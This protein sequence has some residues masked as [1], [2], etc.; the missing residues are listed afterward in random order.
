[1]IDFQKRTRA[2]ARDSTVSSLADG[3]IQPLLLGG[4]SPELHITSERIDGGFLLI[5][6]DTDTNLV[7]KLKLVWVLFSS[8]DA[9]VRL[10][11]AFT[12]SAKVGRIEF[13]EL[14]T[15]EDGVVHDSL[16]R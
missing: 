9:G 15:P 4:G 3:H 1:M 16:S 11:P 2:V 14:G 8:A 12:G 13:D 6:P 10:L 7:I 5:S